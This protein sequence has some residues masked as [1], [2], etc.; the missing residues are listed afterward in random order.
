MD[1]IQHV[2]EVGAH[3]I[4][5]VDVDHAGDLVVVR[6]APHGLGLGLHAALGAHDGDRAVQHAQGALHLH[7]EVHMARCV[8]DVDAGL[9]KLVPHPLPVAGGGGGSDGDAA[10]LLLR[11]PVHSGRALMGFTDLIVH[12]GIIQDTLRGGRLACINVSHNAD[13]SCVFQ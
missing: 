10:L 2:V 11:H 6:L 13:I 4:H 3:D 7:G 1:H 12:T 9:G 8:D 5:L